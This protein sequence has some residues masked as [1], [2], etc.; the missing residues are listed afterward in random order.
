MQEDTSGQRGYITK[1]AFTGS[2][3]EGVVEIIS[4]RSRDLNPGPSD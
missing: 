1:N 4:L 2:T 3:R